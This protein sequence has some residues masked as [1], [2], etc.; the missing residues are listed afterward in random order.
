MSELDDQQLYVE[1]W[2]EQ[3][4]DDAP[5]AHLI[6]SATVMRIGIHDRVRLWNRG[7]LAGELT[8]VAGD[9]ERIAAA[10]GLVDGSA[11]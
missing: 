1:R 2:F 3:P 10:H 5:S 9:G 11:A 8:V 4:G 6:S 7:G